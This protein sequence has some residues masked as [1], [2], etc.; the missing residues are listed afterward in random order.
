MF[1]SFASST[2]LVN[3]PPVTPEDQALGNGTLGVNQRLVPFF[4]SMRG[5]RLGI[6]MFDFYETPSNLVSLYLSLLPPNKTSTYG[7]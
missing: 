5:K 2:N 3:D 1:W 6:V 7:F 4:E